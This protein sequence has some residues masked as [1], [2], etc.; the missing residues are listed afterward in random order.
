MRSVSLVCVTL[1]LASRL[2]SAQTSTSFDEPSPIGNTLDRDWL[3]DLPN[4]GNLFGLLETT[5]PPLI[6]DR[7][8]NSGLWT[9]QGARV[10]GF[11]TSPTQST[12]RLG[13]VD[14]TDPTGSGTPL[15]FPDLELWQRVDVAP[16][17]SPIDGPS[18]MGLD[19]RLHPLSASSRWTA[20]GDGMTARGRLAH[21]AALTNVPPVARLD[22]WDRLAAVASGPL[23]TPRTGGGARTALLGTSW[24]RGSQFDR[25]GTT[26]V[27]STLG[28]AFGQIVLP[29]S[30]GDVQALGWVQH[31][32]APLAQHAAFGQS[33]VVRG[34]TTGHAQF[35]LTRPDTGAGT[36]WRLHGAF[37]GQDRTVTYAPDTGPVFE[38]LVDGSMSQLASLAPETVRQWTV[39]GQAIRPGLVFGGRRHRL[40]AGLDLS[41]ATATA[42]AFFSGLAGELLD[43]GTARLWRF[44]DPAP[45]SHRHRVIMTGHVADTWA[46]SPRVTLDAGLKVDVTSGGADGAA[47][48][49]G[50]QTVLPQAHV[51]WVVTDGGTAMFLG[52]QRTAYRL[53]LDT[54]AVGDPGAPTADVYLWNASTPALP[55]SVAGRTL[56]ARMGPGTGGSS[57]FSAIDPSLGRPIADEIA[58]GVESG[59]M[60]RFRFRILGV[61]KRETSL[62]GIVNIGVTDESYTSFTVADPGSDV[63]SQDDDRFIPVFNQRPTT[64]G[65]DRYRLSNTAQHDA[66]SAALE[67][68]GQWTSNRLLL[69]GGATAD[70]AQ[71]SATNR[72]FG[73]IENDELALG[74]LFLNPNAA[75][76]AR[77][78]LFVD[79]GFTI[80]LR[81]IYRFPADI[82]LGAIARY[83]DGQP[84]ARMLIFRNL[85][86]GPEAV[87]AFVNG[88]SRFTFTG[89]LDLRLQKGFRVGRER[90][91]LIVDGFNVLNLQY[92][93]EERTATLPDVRPPTVLQPPP[94]LHV[95]LRLTF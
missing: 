33:A 7:F 12:F 72:G 24:T 59:Q 43:G 55:G 57:T 15:L 71:A 29:T 5:A 64:F 80:K 35:S 83:Q 23:G 77:G 13:V 46:L 3:R 28:S 20:T 11:F 38:R 86:Q 44:T 47:E 30:R 45:P 41:G 87:R 56:V 81:G 89:T 66:R 50:W 61:A 2:A 14:L 19:I 32:R 6:S 10:G 39:G 93:V 49:I 1:L 63:G 75:T 65:F 62:I 36:R 69:A 48:G 31:A 91:D 90:V 70:I 8:S 37:T 27:E 82:R 92:E 68:S 73:A 85:N 25:A 79:R 88:D 58:F 52:Y 95:G 40:R 54:L 53:G 42:S 22:G 74:E 26:A 84:F 60:G 9:G 21:P 16:S 34:A 76:Y 51:R 78:R 94:A 17:F 18:A 67:L 4:S